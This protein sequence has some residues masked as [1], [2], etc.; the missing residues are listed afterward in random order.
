MATHLKI[1]CECKNV[2][3]KGTFICSVEP[4]DDKY[5]W[6]IEKDGKTFGGQADSQQDAISEAMKLY[7]R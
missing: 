7:D 3:V 4:K 6:L 5:S 1:L 2:E